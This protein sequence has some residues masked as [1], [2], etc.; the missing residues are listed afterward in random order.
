M[1]TTMDRLL[2][3]WPP[4][5]TQSMPVRVR[6]GVPEPHPKYE[7]E[8]TLTIEGFPDKPPYSKGMAGDDPLLALSYA[9][10]VAPLHLRLMM[11]RGGRL[12]WNGKENLQFPSMFSEPSQDWQL[13]PTEGGEPRKLWIRL[14]LPERIDDRWSVLLTCTDCKTWETVERHIQADTWPEVLERA[15]AAVPA[16]LREYADKLGGG[17]LEELHSSPACSVEREAE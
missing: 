10:A 14:A 4:G 9:L 6:I 1:K 11:K 3:Y 12:T 8:S 7:W 5:A 2:E 17:T 16:L 15:A 13:T